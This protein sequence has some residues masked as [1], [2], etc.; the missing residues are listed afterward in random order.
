MYKIVVVTSARSD[1]GLLKWTMH[2]IKENPL[3]ELQIIAT[4]GHLSS[5]QGLTYRYIEKDGFHLNEK[6]P[7]LLSSNTSSSLAKSLGLCNLYLADSLERLSPDMLLVLGDRYELLSICSTALIMNIPIAHI[8]GGDVTEGAIDNE[9]RNAVTM[10]ATLHFPGVDDSAK[11]IMRMRNSSDNIFVVG[12]PG[13]ENLCREE[14]MTREELSNNLHIDFN[15]DWILFTYHPE[16]KCTVEENL[17]VSKR[18]LK[19]LFSTYS[20]AEIIITKSNA[21]LGGTQLNELWNFF[22]EKHMNVSLYSSLGQ[23]RYNSL[24][25]Q[26]AAVIGN[27]SSGI[28]EAPNL[29]TP[30][31]NIGNRQKGRHICSNVIQTENVLDDGLAIAFSKVKKMSELKTKTPDYYWG[32]GKTAEKIINSIS[33]F[34][35]NNK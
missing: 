30:V 26:V 33:D 12:E 29:G 18:I 1:Y 31:L 15:K 3:F 20:D 19:H 5:E 21:D 24:M 17:Q 11:N 4:G 22:Q 35:K 34:L 9:V 32:D 2:S 25:N 8:S 27:S 7:I 13:I 28:V 14:L 16:T 6:I 23:K 10:M